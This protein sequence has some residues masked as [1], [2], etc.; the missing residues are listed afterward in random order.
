[1]IYIQH[2][3]KDKVIVWKFDKIVKLYISDR[4]SKRPT[5]TLM[6][7]T[8]PEDADL[9]NVSLA[10]STSASV[11]SPSVRRSQRL[12]ESP[13]I[14][15]SLN[16]SSSRGRRVKASTLK[17]KRIFGVD[18]NDYSLPNQSLNISEDE[19]F[20][21]NSVANV[22][23]NNKS[24]LANFQSTAQEKLATYSTQTKILIASLVL[25]FM[26]LMAEQ[27][28]YWAYIIICWLSH[29]LTSFRMIFFSVPDIVS[30]SSDGKVG[31]TDSWQ[32]VVDELKLNFDADIGTL[33]QEI[34]KLHLKHLEAE[35]EKLK[36]IEQFPLINVNNGTKVSYNDDTRDGS[37]SSSNNSEIQSKLAVIE[38]QY[39]QLKSTLKSL[40]NSFSEYEVKRGEIEALSDKVDTLVKDF[41]TLKSF[42][43]NPIQNLSGNDKFLE[44]LSKELEGIK[45]TISSI[46]SDSLNSKEEDEAKFISLALDKFPDLPTIG[47]KFENFEMKTNSLEQKLKSELSLIIEKQSKWSE[48]LETEVQRRVEEQMKLNGYFRDDDGMTDW[49]DSGLGTKVIT[50]PGTVTHPQMVTTSLKIFGFTVWRKTKTPEVIIQRPHQ[51]DCFMFL[52]NSGSILFTL[53][54]NVTIKSVG[55]QTLIADMSQLPKEVV[56]FDS[57][58]NVEMKRVSVSQNKSGF[59]MIPIE[60]QDSVDR[61]KMTILNNWG[62]SNATCIG[63][64]KLLNSAP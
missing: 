26:L 11:S 63:E 16:Q 51:G 61:I 52:G 48:N 35:Q 45:E 55:I 57:R 31:M 53:N 18:A 44:N 19:D 20:H 41:V 33:K 9:K 8:I 4:M 47:E 60:Y 42:D 64:V 56:L 62:N 34:R 22:P 17:S 2:S 29:S 40:S 49:A 6:D 5:R 38:L 24:I 10:A 30:S 43:R 58:R 23:D 14:N 1:L 36:L 50:A 12:L 13:S 39:G 21:A 37:D 27:C 7:E 32:S 3:D 54:Q 59:E 28:V 25:V 15:Y 46:N